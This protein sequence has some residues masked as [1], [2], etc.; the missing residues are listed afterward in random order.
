MYNRFIA[1]HLKEALAFSPAVYLAGPR[2]SG[3]STL[4]EKS[5]G[6]DYFS[7]DSINTLHIAKESP[8][9]F[10][11]SLQNPC[12]LDEIQRAPELILPIKEHIDKNKTAGHF[13]LTGSANILSMPSVADSLA[14]RMIILNLLPLSSGEILGRRNSWIENIF[15]TP[16][17]DL[18]SSIKPI[19]YNDLCKFIIH[20]GYPALQKDLNATQ[21]KMWFN[22]YIQTIIERDL[23]D[24][25]NFSEVIRMNN[26]FRH[27]SVRSAL[28]LN[29]TDLARSLQIPATT[30]S[31][32]MA[33]LETLFIFSKLP[34]WF[35]NQNKRMTKMPKLFLNDSGILCHMLNI[36]IDSDFTARMEWGQIVETFI[37]TELKK[38]LSYS[39]SPFGLFYY[40]THSGNEVDFV[41]ENP[42]GD[43][44]GIEV[45]ASKSISHNFTNGMMD[46]RDSAGTNFKAG[47]ILYMGDK[48]LPLGNNIF[49][50]PI[51][52]VV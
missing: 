37:Y 9:D 12:T 41:L 48:V 30:T 16:I 28:S 23:K 45:K 3:K 51:G 6:R 43:V 39:L 13:L 33:A 46:L 49:A 26:L 34:A 14:G 32:Y 50:V 11:S 18:F 2:Q 27:A 25:T 19:E 7:F 29:T 38:Q 8:L 4:V 42:N 31:L 1:S 10:I 20:G 35:R 15:T 40:R 5:A 47:I 21:R 24:I 36:T 52:S 22:S 44:I 17:L